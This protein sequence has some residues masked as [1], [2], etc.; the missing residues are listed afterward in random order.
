MRKSILYWRKKHFSFFVDGSSVPF[1][2]ED[3][4]LCANRCFFIG[5]KT[6]VFL[7]TVALF[8]GGIF[9]YFLIRYLPVFFLFYSY[10]IFINSF[11]IF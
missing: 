10:N 1:F 8:I 11:F 4:W 7:L 9:F 5:E 3:I 6:F 2:I